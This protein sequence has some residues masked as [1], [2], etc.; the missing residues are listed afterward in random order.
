MGSAGA[1]VCSIYFGLIQTLLI[2]AALYLL[3]LLI[4]RSSFGEAPSVSEGAVS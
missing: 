2:G 1:I 3:A 4:L